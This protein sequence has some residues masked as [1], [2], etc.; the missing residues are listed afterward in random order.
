MIKA[1]LVDLDGVLRVWDA[2][3]E[4]Q[5][6]RA[7]GLAPGAIR[8]A[9]FARELLEPAITGRVTDEHW[10]SQIAARLRETHACEC[11]ERV[12]SL[13]SASPGQID[14]EVLELLRASRP[15]ARLAL[16]TNA[17]SR[18]SADLAR[19]GVEQEFDFIF[20]SAVLGAIKPELA[21]FRAALNEM[22]VASAEALFV[23]DNAGHVS[24][25]EQL[26]ILGHGYRGIEA[27]RNELSRHGLLG[28]PPPVRTV[29]RR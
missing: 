6:E 4:T 16:I 14:A 5:A 18:L 23:D 28:A 7:G 22:D 15:R 26:G 11:A 12:V 3:N 27:L 29:P 1:L 19:L 20:N 10:R 13:W 9:A 2:E 25:A 8:R 24:A 21:I 17:T